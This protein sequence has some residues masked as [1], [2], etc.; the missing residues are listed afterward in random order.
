MVGLEVQQ[1][2]L[3]AEVVLEVTLEMAVLAEVQLAQLRAQMG[4]AEAEVAVV[5]Q[6]EVAVV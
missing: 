2:A 1:R 3:Q 4:L 5:A 6:A